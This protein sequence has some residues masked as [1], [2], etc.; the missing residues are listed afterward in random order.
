MPLK[1]TINKS[2]SSYTSNIEGRAEASDNG[3]S[4]EIDSTTVED[5]VANF[6]RWYKD[7][8]QK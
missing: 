7:Y 2:G 8:Y 1:L 6:V 4:W 3:M 5:G